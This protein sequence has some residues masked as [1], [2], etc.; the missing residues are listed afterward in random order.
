MIALKA[1]GYAFLM[2]VFA[3]WAG[4]SYGVSLLVAWLAADIEVIYWK[5]AGLNEIY[6]KRSHT[7]A[8][9]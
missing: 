2:F 1:L 3:R 9:R 8:N 4:W 5:V 6:E 7:K